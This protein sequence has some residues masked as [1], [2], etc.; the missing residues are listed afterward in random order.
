MVLSRQNSGSGVRLSQEAVKI[1]RAWLQD[2]ALHPYPSELE[3][4]ELKRKTGLRKEQI[5]NWLANARRRGK[6]PQVLPSPRN[7][8]SGSYFNTPMAS[9]V[10]VDVPRVGERQLFQD[11]SPLAR[12]V[13]QVDT[14]EASVASWRLT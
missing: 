9:P 3:K 6:V 13:A 1:L 7:L 5:S 11:M 2:N 4:Q 10:G 14:V 8:S 12:Y